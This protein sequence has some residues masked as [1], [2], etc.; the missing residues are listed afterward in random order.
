[1]KKDFK[2]A[3]WA[4]L[5]TQGDGFFCLLGL[6]TGGVG[7]Y[8]GLTREEI[9][10]R[11]LILGIASL[12]VSLLFLRHVVTEG[13]LWVRAFYCDLSPTVSAL[14]LPP[15]L[16]LTRLQQVKEVIAKSPAREIIPI[17]VGEHQAHWVDDYEFRIQWTQT[18]WCAGVGVSCGGILFPF[19]CYRIAQQA[20]VKIPKRFQEVEVSSILCWKAN[21]LYRYPATLP[22]A[23]LEELTKGLLASTEEAFQQWLKIYQQRLAEDFAETE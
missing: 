19:E 22:A 21:Q 1:M 18:T 15:A 17:K 20:P 3:L 2:E 7:L 23:L 10:W 14:E 11:A 6:A 5:K 16:L 9:A 12:L 4:H 8:F 13:I